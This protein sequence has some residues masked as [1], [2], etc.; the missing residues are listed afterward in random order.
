MGDLVAVDGNKALRECG[1]CG[2]LSGV[3]Y[4][5]EGFLHSVKLLYPHEVYGYRVA[6]AGVFRYAKEVT[7]D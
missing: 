3:E 1:Y 7:D 4:D 5:G 2:K 6:F